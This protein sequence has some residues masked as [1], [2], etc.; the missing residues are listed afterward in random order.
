MFKWKESAQLYSKYMVVAIIVLHFDCS[1]MR[2]FGNVH[3]LVK[4]KR[5]RV[6]SDVL[7]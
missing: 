3:S 4:G 1:N 6:A 5:I 7:L 2:I